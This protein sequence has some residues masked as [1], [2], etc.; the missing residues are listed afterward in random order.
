MHKDDRIVTL[1]VFHKDEKTCGKRS[2]T[3]TKY[4][5]SLAIRS[6]TYMDIL[7][8]MRKEQPRGRGSK[9]RPISKEGIMIPDG[10]TD[11]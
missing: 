4:G 2:N 8:V 11:A 7:V 3:N 9:A 10:L 1:T 6:S 5:F